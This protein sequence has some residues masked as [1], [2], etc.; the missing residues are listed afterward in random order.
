MLAVVT[1][2]AR[3]LAMLEESGSI[4]SIARTSGWIG[5][6]PSAPA[7]DAPP[8]A[9]GDAA[10]AFVPFT[11]PQTTEL[12]PLVEFIDQVGRWRTPITP[13]MRQN[14]EAMAKAKS[15]FVKSRV[16]MIA[17]IDKAL[18]LNPTD[19]RNG[20]L[21]AAQ[22]DLSGWERLRAL[23][24]ELD[25]RVPDDQLVGIQTVNQLLSLV[26]SKVT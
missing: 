11:V 17:A 21:H 22:E 14:P 9:P 2:P 23:E 4:E 7:I 19:D 1:P 10:P 26:E 8:P 18:T 3:A 16:A 24:R 15:D 5:P 6:E 20:L 13:E 12:Q 25:I